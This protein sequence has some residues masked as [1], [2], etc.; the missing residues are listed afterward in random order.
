[1]KEITIEYLV[2]L[3]LRRL[4]LMLIAAAVFAAA[5]F[6]YCRFLADPVYRATSQIVVSNGAVIIE[7]SLGEDGSKISGS[8]I[9]SSMY[10][11]DVCVGLLESQDFYKKLS[12]KLENKYS[13]SKLGSMISVGLNGEEDLFINI[14]ANHGDPEEAKKVANTMVAMAP[15]YI[16]DFMPSAKIMITATADSAGKVSPRTSMTTALFFIIGAVF[17][18]IIALIVDLNDKTIKGVSDFTATYHIPV[19]GGVPDFESID[20]QG[21]YSYA[22]SK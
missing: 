7:D 12:D 21:G 16:K 14:A 8:D 20:S 1:M 19:L 3:L 17:V 15:D 4:V 6:G 18:Y 10:L 2:D 22:E 5:A 9:Q 13:Y 11:A